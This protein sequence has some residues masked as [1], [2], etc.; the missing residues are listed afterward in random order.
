MQ[1]VP[2]KRVC[3]SFV[4]NLKGTTIEIANDF[5]KEIDEIRQKRY[6]IFRKAKHAK[7]SAHFHLY[8]SGYE[9]QI[10]PPLL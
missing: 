1:L 3:L 7:Q 6:P 8:M 5:L 9:N 10:M 2:R 4:K